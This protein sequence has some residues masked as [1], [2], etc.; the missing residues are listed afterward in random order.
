MSDDIIKDSTFAD[1]CVSHSHQV[2]YH[3][4]ERLFEGLSEHRAPRES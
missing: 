3:I 1:I 2:I 4:L